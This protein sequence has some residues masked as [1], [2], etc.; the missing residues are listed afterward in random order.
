MQRKSFTLTLLA[1]LCTLLF[2]ACQKEEEMKVFDYKTIITVKSADAKTHY[3]HNTHAVEWD[4]GDRISVIRGNSSASNPFSTFDIIWPVQNNEARFGSQATLPAS[5]IYYAIYPAQ[6]DLSINEGRLSCVA[7]QPQQTLTENSFGSGNNTAVGWNNTTTMPFRNVGGLAKIALR[8]TAKVVSIKI[9]NNGSDKLSGR[10]YIDLMSD[11]LSILWDPD[12]SSNEV[13]ALAE[14]L[15]SGVTVSGGKF[16]YIVLP[17]CTLTDYSVTVTDIDGNVYSKDFSNQVVISR[18]TV[19]LLGAFE[20]I[21][22]PAQN[23]FFF[24]ANTDDVFDAIQLQESNGRFFADGVTLDLSRSTYDRVTHKGIAVFTGTITRV[25]SQ[26]FY[27]IS[28]TSITLPSSV[29]SLDRGCF[30]GSQ[31]EEIAIAENITSIASDAFWYATN[32]KK[33]ILKA[34]FTSVPF[35]MNSP[36]IS[37]LDFPAT[38]TSTG[39]TLIL[40]EDALGEHSDSV[41]IIFRNTTSSVVMDGVFL[42]SLGYLS[43]LA[44]LH[45]YV[46]AALVDDYKTSYGNLRECFSPIPDDLQ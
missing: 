16:F 9:T 32:L 21:A 1:A 24:T 34:P 19:S 38:I 14:D 20:V 29:T 12:N 5:G 18:R 33:V 3:N 27:N 15:S 25:P 41:T 28:I 30:W 11:N 43:G 31:L 36:K 44:P 10:G 4:E 42:S 45:I 6:D 39:N 37:Y 17:P 13:T 22:P 40:D 7:I 8:G 2:A 26:A 46:P 23:E 35:Y